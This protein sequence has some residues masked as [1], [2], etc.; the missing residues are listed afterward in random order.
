MEVIELEKLF[1]ENNGIMK[2]SDMYKNGVTKY[3]IK[4]YTD[5]LVLERI[6]KGYYKLYAEDMSDIKIISLLIPDAV[7]CFDSALYNYGYSDRTP[8]EWHLAIDKD[9]SKSR[10]RIDY[11]Y[12][13]AYYIEHNLVHLG[14]EEIVIEGIEVKIY[15]RERLICDCL[16]Y[17]RKMDVEIFNKAI[18]NYVADPKK[19]ISKL[20]EI[21]KIRGVEK[22][23]YDK[24][25][26]WL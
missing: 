26:T 24:I 5:T 12:I 16:K 22:K 13:K 21:A 3:E 19:N 15:S 11:P 1:H 23:V 9:T 2:T 25:G 20:M 14:V 8:S 18:I 7:L 17:E 6:S 10:V 4:K